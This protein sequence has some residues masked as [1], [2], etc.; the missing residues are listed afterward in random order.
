MMT[1]PSKQAACGT[2]MAVIFLLA[3]LAVALP[4]QESRNSGTQDSSLEK[5]RS[6]AE[7]Q[8]EIFL[9]LLRKKQYSRAV[10]EA[11]RIFELKWPPDQEPLLTKELISLSGRLVH[12]EQTPSGLLL[13]ERNLKYFHSVESRVSILKE[14]GYLHKTLGHDDQALDCF[15]QAKEL[16]VESVPRE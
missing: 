6:I 10:D 11:G 16:E 1:T 3:G 2:M 13:L 14:M 5:M 8:H 4:L 12:A 7:S 9:L 15:R